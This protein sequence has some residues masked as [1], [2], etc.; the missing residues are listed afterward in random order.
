MNYE[1]AIAFLRELGKFGIHVGLERSLA[2]SRKTGRPEEAYPIVHVA[3]TNGKGSV[4]AMI[5]S[6]LRASGFRVGLYTCLL[7]TSW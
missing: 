6:V 2:L 4:S 7:Y 3:G 5:D 1:E